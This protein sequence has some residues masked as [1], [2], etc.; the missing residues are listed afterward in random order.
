M[1]YFKYSESSGFMHMLFFIGDMGKYVFKMYDASLNEKDNAEL[2]RKW[3][4]GQ[5]PQ[6]V[7]KVTRAVQENSAGCPCTM[8]QA[9]TDN[10]FVELEKPIDDLVCFYTFEEGFYIDILGSLVRTFLE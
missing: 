7:D 2:C 9:F 10:R 8:V 6:L 3:A 5:N 4:K 1:L